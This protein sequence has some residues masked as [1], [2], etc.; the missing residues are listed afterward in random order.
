MG[1]GPY[2]VIVVG[3]G[4]MGSA[5][6]HHLARRGARVLG[7]E[8]FDI[9]HAH[10]SSHGITRIIRL[11]YYEDPA[12][13]PLLRRAFELWRALGEEVDERILVTTGSLDAGYEG[14]GVFEGSLASCLEHGLRHEVLTGTEVKRRFPGYR[15]PDAHRALLQPDGGFV[16]SERAIVAHVTLAQRHGADI[17]AREAVTGWSPLP[18]GGV[19]V[20]TTRGVYEAGRLVLSPGAW[21]GDFVPALT[22]IA[23]PERQVLGWFPPDDPGLFAPDRFPV[24]NLMVEE[25]RYYLL[26]VWGVPGLKIGLYH[27]RGETGHADAI[28]RDVDGEDEAILRRCIGR[29][30][31]RADGPTMALHACMF[32]NT[33]DEHFIIDALPGQEDVIVASPCS[34]HGYKFASVVG[35][36]L[37]DLALSGRTGFDLSMFRLGRF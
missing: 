14:S 27:H 22:G 33:P 11:A 7:L 26:P 29:Y 21:I 28:R 10:G 25:G 19:R 32:T 30:F 18:G 20:T 4:G 9:P 36:I 5:A 24:L 13:V 31:P 1:N 15:L 35:E 34:G 23:V 3:V 8:R 17:R 16:L 12:Y 2:D 37:A 6:C